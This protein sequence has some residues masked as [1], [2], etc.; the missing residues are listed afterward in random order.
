MDSSDEEAERASRH[1]GR[2]DSSSDDELDALDEGSPRPRLQRE[3]KRK[4]PT[5]SSLGSAVAVSSPGGTRVK[6]LADLVR[7][8]KRQKAKKKRRMGELDDE[9]GDGDGDQMD[10]VESYAKNTRQLVAGWADDDAEDDEPPRAFARWE[11][12]RWDSLPGYVPPLDRRLAAAD[13]VARALREAHK[14][15]GAAPLRQLLAAHGPQLCGRPGGAPPSLLRWLL[16]LTA[17]CFDEGTAT[18][19]FELLSR[20]LAKSAGGWPSLSLIAAT[21]NLYGTTTPLPNP[22]AELTLGRYRAAPTAP[23]PA[24]AAGAAGGGAGGGAAAVPSPVRK[25]KKRK[26]KGPSKKEPLRVGDTIVVKFEETN[27]EQ[28]ATVYD[29]RV[30]MTHDN[31]SVPPGAKIEQGSKAKLSAAEFI[32]KRL[33]GFQNNETCWGPHA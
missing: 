15:G 26:P 33:F 29:G 13:A 19:A 2:L 25:R 12:A 27:G 9:D 18:A 30:V 21:I 3:A 17:C 4:Q 11:A 6:S 10:A 16:G 8:K 14:R 28:D 1:A 5:A 7:D 20:L 23:T 22:S 31:G 24:G 32:G